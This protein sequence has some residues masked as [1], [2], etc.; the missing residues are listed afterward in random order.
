MKIEVMHVPAASVAEGRPRAAVTRNL[1]MAR[2][3]WMYVLVLLCAS[4]GDNCGS[5]GAVLPSNGEDQ[6]TFGPPDQSLPVFLA[7]GDPC[8]HHGQCSSGFCGDTPQG[9]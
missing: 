9:K 1:A 8:A 2:F 3:S 7:D 4:C 5:G 6:V